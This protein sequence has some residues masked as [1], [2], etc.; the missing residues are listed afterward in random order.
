MFSPQPPPLSH[1]A[2]H[3]DLTMALRAAAAL[4]ARPSAGSTI[5]VASAVEAARARAAEI[6]RAPVNAAAT[7]AASSTAT[8][9]AAAVPV[10]PLQAARAAAAAA[11]AKLG[12]GSS[13]APSDAGDKRS[14]AEAF[15]EKLKEHKKSRWGAGPNDM[16]AASGPADGAADPGKERQAMVVAQLQ[17]KLAAFRKDRGVEAALEEKLRLK[18]YVPEKDP[19]ARNERNWVGIF[20]G[21]DAVNKN[22]FE[23]RFPGCRI[24]VRGEGT[25]LRGGKKLEDTRRRPQGNFR[26]V[27]GL[28]GSLCDSGKGGV[29]GGKGGGGGG[30]GKGR[31]RHRTD[32]DDA[33]ALH[34]LLEADNQQVLDAAREEVMSIFAGKPRGDANALTLFDEGQMSTIATQKTTGTEEC[35]FCGKTGHHHSVCP[36]RKSSF[37]MSGVRCAACGNM[38]HTA[39]DCKGDRSKIA[40]GPGSS[41]PAPSAFEDEDFASFEAELLKRAGL[42]Q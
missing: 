28:G 3:P 10:D 40:S 33:E 39:R 9:N 7:A 8:T 14:A 29:Q 17:D 6:L 25:Q 31:G 2:D 1:M 16:V 18:L 11:A 26:T 42:T 38:G 13:S 4:A 34:V 21:R 20:I 37:T 32:D 12:L 41:G 35:A 24:F 27:D 22:R 15:A 5:S 19:S 23:E 30:G 36:K